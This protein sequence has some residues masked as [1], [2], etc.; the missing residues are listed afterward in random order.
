MARIALRGDVPRDLFWM[1]PLL[2]VDPLGAGGLDADLVVSFSKSDGRES[3]WHSRGWVL[4]LRC[5]GLGPRIGHP[6]VY[7]AN[8]HVAA[9][10]I[11]SRAIGMPEPLLAASSESFAR[12]RDAVAIESTSNVLIE[13]ETGCGK[14]LLAQLIHLSSSVRS[15]LLRVNCAVP[16]EVDADL[17]VLE[18]EG[19]TGQLANR[20]VFLHRVSELTT[21]H[22]RRFANL[23]GQPSAV[24]YLATAKASAHRSCDSREISE[25]LAANF[26]RVVKIAPLYRAPDDVVAL[27]DY[28]LHSANPRLHLDLTAMATLR[29]YRFPGNI[30]ELKNFI[31]RLDVYERAQPLQMVRGEQVDKLLTPPWATPQPPARKMASERRRKRASYPR[32]RLRLVSNR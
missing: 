22:Q 32:P 24:R 16:D 10:F 20:T 31:T 30:R 27:T 2:N 1:L 7:C 5:A 4:G 6:V 29:N 23:M 21:E 28:F 15:E 13:G 26:R 9:S 25:L 14:R 17:C 19:R 11:L 3:N 8:S 12:L 18:S